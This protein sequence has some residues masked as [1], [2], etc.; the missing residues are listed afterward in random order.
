[1]GVEE[2]V[3]SVSETPDRKLIGFSAGLETILSSSSSR[4]SL[5][6]GTSLLRGLKNQFGENSPI[7]MSF[8]DGIAFEICK[9]T[10]LP[11]CGK[12]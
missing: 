7:A 10:H 2:E 3:L 6:R 8:P 1:L 12:K 5:G 11:A 4:N 9:L